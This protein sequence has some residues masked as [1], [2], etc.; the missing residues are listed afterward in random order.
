MARM[1]HELSELDKRMR[2][3]REE[4]ERR[5]AEIEAKRTQEA[6]WAAA[7]ET[8]K[9]PQKVRPKMTAAERRRYTELATLIPQVMM[10]FRWP[11]LAASILPAEWKDIPANPIPEKTRITLRV[12]ADVARFYRKTGPGYQARMNDVLRTFMLARLVE[13]IGISQEP[14]EL[15]MAQDAGQKGALEREA[16]LVRELE[17]MRRKR[18]GIG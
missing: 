12:D 4:V 1:T 16:E 7:M 2:A 17:G 18:T 10:D 5:A 9:K 3:F 11:E 15:M 6:A 14:L 8:A 13:I